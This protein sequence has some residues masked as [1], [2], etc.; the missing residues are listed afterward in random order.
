MKNK[1]L[2]S[3]IL[4]VGCVVTS[5]SQGRQVTSFND[6]WQFKKGP[7]SS[8]NIT[9]MQTWNAKWKDVKIPHTW[10]AKDMQVEHNK[11]YQGEAFYKKSF[12]VEPN[13]KD[14]RLFLKFEG[15]GQVVELFINGNFVGNHKGGYSAFS[16]DISKAVKHGENNEILLKVD[17]SERKDIIP[18]NHNLFG[19]YGGIY[20][21]VW[22]IITDKL[23]I[24]VTDHASSGVYISQNNVNSKSA[25]I[26]V[27]VKLANKYKKTKEV[28]IENSIYDKSDKKVTTKKSTV[29]VTPHGI[30][31]FQHEIALRNPHLW[32]GLKDPYLYKV[33][34]KIKE[35]NKLLDEV[36]QPLGIRSVEVIEGKG[37]FL[38]GKQYPMYGVCR[39]QDWWELGSALENKHHDKDIEMMLEMGATTVRLA[40]YQQSDYFYAKCDSVG[41]LVW[42]EIPFVNRVSGEEGPNSKQQLRELI[43]Q[44]FNHPSI[45]VWGLH[46][47]VYKPHDYTSQLTK[48]LHDIAKTEDPTRYTVAVNGYGHMNHPVNLNADIQG[49]N[50]YYGWYER[51]IQDLESWAKEMKKDYPTYKIMLTEY[52]AGGNTN[53]QTEFLGNTWEYWKPFYPETYQTKTHEIQYGIIK[54]N[55]NILASYVWNMFD[56]AVPKWSRGGIEARNHKGLVTFDRKLKKDSFY[57]YKANWSKEPVLYL[58][59]RR[60]IE[61]EKKQTQVTV[62]S[63]IGKPKVLVNGIE[64]INF[65]IGET[66]I[67]YVFEN[68][69]LKKGNNIVEAIIEKDGKKY[70]DK[71]EWNYSSEKS[72]NLKMKENKKEHSGF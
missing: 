67:H 59:Q 11:F 58:T 65:K 19:V 69:I 66:D 33:V 35:G 51:K 16:F 63:N 38:N 23:N 56:F 31:T 21:P 41:L 10:N 7:F 40:H 39:H 2:V 15:V 62:Y 54:N 55:P 53:H 71:I 45:Y 52:G 29:K 44:N 14:K 8:S 6:G 36:T 25:A 43:R 18:I 22:L 27:K 50:R 42:A 3:I 47:E 9:F 1:I 57:W 34:T 4:I 48:E 61:R 37:V 64:L 30:Q 17:N 46:N 24:S 20:R 49:M 28:I 72:N 13:L 26:T 68:V 70:I 12:F 5:L 60:L 32:Q